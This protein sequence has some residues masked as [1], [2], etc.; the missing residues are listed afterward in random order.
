MLKAKIW[1]IYLSKDNNEKL[2][3]L[4]I[5]SC[6]KYLLHWLCVLMGKC[7]FVYLLGVSKVVQIWKKDLISL[8]KWKILILCWIC[9]WMGKNVF[10]FCL[11][12]EKHE[13]SKQTVLALFAVHDKTKA[14]VCLAMGPCYLLGSQ[15]CILLPLVFSSGRKGKPSSV[16]N[17]ASG[18]YFL[19][20]W[21]VCI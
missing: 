7:V 5:S 17:W 15:V 16:E 13:F 10:V 12:W 19:G 8:E 9:V 14:R 18:K 20:Q 6:K 11:K 4:L 1:K 3:S 21:H 2:I